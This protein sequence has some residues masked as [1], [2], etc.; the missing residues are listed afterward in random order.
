ME[1]T[2]VSASDVA[3]QIVVAAQN[4]IAQALIRRSL[5]VNHDHRT[6]FRRAPKYYGCDNL[7][8][9]LLFFRRLRVGLLIKKSSFLATFNRGPRRS[10]LC[11]TAAS[12]ASNVPGK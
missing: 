6:R 10:Y 3:A 2:F 12:S 8:F 11:R 5:Q 1:G 7:H 4:I 9:A